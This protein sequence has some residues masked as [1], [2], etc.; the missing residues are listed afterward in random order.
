MIAA[1][2]SLPQTKESESLIK[3]LLASISEAAKKFVSAKSKREWKLERVIWRAGELK[4]K[5]AS[6][7][8]AR[9]DWHA[10]R[11]S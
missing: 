4:I 6:P 3:N 8:L 1:V 11:A 7:L 5:E 2:E 10:S 9:V